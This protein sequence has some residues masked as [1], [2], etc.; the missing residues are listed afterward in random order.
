MYVFTDPYIF[1]Y[2]FTD[3]CK[4][5]VQP[6][7]MTAAPQSIHIYTHTAQEWRNCTVAEHACSKMSILI[8]TKMK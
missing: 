6:M 3:P 8:F 4:I 1:M 2:I 7:D 5:W